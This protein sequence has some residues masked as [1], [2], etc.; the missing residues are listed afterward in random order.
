[1]G[2]SKPKAAAMDED[3]LARI[4]KQEAAAASSYHD[5]ELAKAQIEGLKRYFAEPYGNEIKGRCD[6]VT[7]DIEDAVAWMMPELIRSFASAD[8]LVSLKARSAEDDQPVQIGANP[9][10]TPKMSSRSKADV[11]AAYL[12]HIYFEDND[13]LKVTHDVTFDGLVQRIGIWRIDWEDPKADPSDIIEGVSDAQ[14]QKYLFDPE[15]EILAFDE[16]D[17]GQEKKFIIEVQRTPKMGRVNVEAVPPEEF[18]IEKTARCVSEAKYH[19]RKR[20]VYLSELKADYPDKA[21]DLTGK[22]GNSEDEITDDARL[23]ARF[24]NDSVDWTNGDD[25]AGR[26]EVELHEEFMRID[27]DGDGVVELRAIKRVGSVILENVRVKHSSYV[28]WSPSRVSHRAV[29]RSIPDMLADVAKIRTAITRRYLDGLSQTVTP[30]TFVNTQ[31]FTADDKGQDGLDALLDNELGAVIPV[32]GNPRDAIYETVTPDV[33]GPSLNALEYFDQRGQEASGVTKHSQGM[34]PSQLNKTA[35]GIDLLQAAAKTRVEMVARWLGLG[36]EEVFKRIL[37]LVVSHQDKPRQIKLFGEWCE[38]DPRTWSDE[39]AVAV[40]IGAAGVSKQTRLANLMMLSQKQEQVIMSAGPSNPLVTL[41]H[42]RNTYAAMASAMG[43][44]DATQFFGE[45]PEDFQPEPQPDP[46]VAEVQ[47]KLQLEQMKAEQTLQ[48]DYAKAQNAAQV[49]AQKMQSE[50][51]K[52][53][54]ELQLAREKAAA[55][56]QLAREKMF[57]EMEL[58]RERAQFEA[59]QAERDSQRNHDAAIVAAKSRAMNGSGSKMSSNRPG[60]SLAE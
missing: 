11:M 13:G 36:L 17:E 57:M 38:V 6:V 2:M 31:A 18:A 5:S 32:R 21:H 19:R 52:A 54:L 40:N 49:E 58:A 45:V 4:L 43:F 3:R 46:K 20:K 27:F 55:E 9:D 7:H 12:S 51:E 14:L 48:L 26:Q 44:R 35:T 39:M 34:D 56:M 33:S 30:R 60:G 8:D 29:G 23:S 24:P 15:Y 47:G 25:E 22:S 16:Y 10:G 42:L 1:M 28:T 53:A 41:S 59:Q 50:R 37:H